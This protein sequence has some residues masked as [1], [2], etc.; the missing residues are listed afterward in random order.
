VADY[1]LK[2]DGIAGESVDAKH[3]DEIELVSFSWGV[4]Q[5]LLREG[6]GG[7][8]TGRAQFKEFEIT[9]K[10]DKASPLIFLSTVSG[11]HIKEASLTAR[12]AGKVALEYLVIKFNDVLVTSYQQAGGADFPQEVI[13]F[14]F[15]QIQF[16]QTSGEAVAPVQIGWNLAQ[17][18]K[19]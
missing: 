14:D 8:S 19:I 7:A 17:N 4:T 18:V 12:R 16:Q 2:L 6:S 3:K 9:K 13:A 10:V 11:K 1:F 15:T 5:Q